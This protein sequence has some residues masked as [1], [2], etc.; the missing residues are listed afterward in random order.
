M[1][2][3]AIRELIEGVDAIEMDPTAKRQFRQLVR[4]I[5]AAHGFVWIERQEREQFAHELLLRGVSR[6]TIRERLMAHFG[7]SRQ[8]AYRTIRGALQLYRKPI[9]NETRTRFNAPIDNS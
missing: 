7:V 3:V 9:L 2:S 1:R 8:Q 6:A 5:G 4:A